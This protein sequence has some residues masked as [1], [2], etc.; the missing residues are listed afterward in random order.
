MEEKNKIIIYKPQIG[1][2]ELRIK[3]DK[4]TVWLNQE[5]IAQLF[6][7]ERSV[8]TKH[9]R[10]IFDSGELKKSSVCAFFAHTAKDG[11]TYKTQFYSLDAIISVG[12]R[13]NSKK[14]T[15][16]RV[17][18]TKTLRDY[19]LKGYVVNEKRLA[20]V[21]EKFYELQNAVSFLEKK[22]KSK[23]LRGQEQEILTLLADYSRTLTLL[24][25]Y[26]RRKIK[27]RKGEKSKFVLGYDFCLDIIK[28]LK[29][30]LILRKEAGHI[31]GNEMDHRFECVIKGLYQTFGGKQLYRTVE[32]KSAHLLY[33]TIKDH[34]FIDGNKRIASFLFVY[35]LDKSG[36]LYR[37]TGERKINDNTLTALSILIAES[38]PKE[39]NQMVALISQLLR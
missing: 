3:L 36:Y 35:F 1:N 27:E 16:F 6:A 38:L 29:K 2:I 8:I 25:Q 23:T 34:P 20:E 33:L 30:E 26:D 12:Y 14:A 37:L 28:Q 18:A 31:F 15:Q 4:E 22:S 7:V 11:K 24:E 32:D 10:N 39:K 21:K 19:L 5:Q 13:V 9:L 17:W